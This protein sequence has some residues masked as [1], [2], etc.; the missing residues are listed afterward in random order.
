[1][2]DQ[3]AQ[4]QDDLEQFSVGLDRSSVCVR[5]ERTLYP[6]DSIYGAAYVFIDRCYVLLDVPDE[7]HISV[8]L[9]GRESL[10]AP[11]LA[12][13]GGEF[14]NE[15][16]TQT[17]RHKITERN[18]LTIETATV[19][20]LAGAA[21]PPRVDDLDDLDDLRGD[22]LSDLPEEDLGDDVFDDPLGIATP[23][24]EKYG[25]AAEPETEAA[26]ANAS[27]DGPGA[28]SEADPPE[29]GKGEE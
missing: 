2:V 14:A 10:D 18:R 16:L 1:M 24:E 3:A 7:H 13:L 25:E 11:A 26:A 20:A 29:P 5:F 28:R 12:A 17:W 22:D 23:W 15:L 19:Q 27:G 6:L 8:E 9:R 21:G 4:G